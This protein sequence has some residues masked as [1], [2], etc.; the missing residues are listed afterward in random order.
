MLVGYLADTNIGPYDQPVPSVADS[1]RKID[2]LIE[3][4]IEAERAGFDSVLVPERHMRT[5]TYMP[6]ALTLLTILARETSKIRLG[7]YASVL[8]C[9]DPMQFAERAAQVDL[10]SHGRLFLTLARGYNSDYWRMMG[11]PEEKLTKRFIEGVEIVRRAFAGER[12]SFK[13][14]IFDLDDVFLTPLPYQRGEGPPIWGGGHFPAAIERAGTYSN[15]WSG[16]PFPYE[17]DFWKEVTTAYLEAAERSGRPAMI[18][19]MRDGFV[20]ETREK[21]Y[22]IFGDHVV[23]EN[24]F[25][26]RAGGHDP[27][28]RSEDEVTVENLRPHLVLGDPEDC[29]EALRH[30]ERDYG[31]EYVVLRMRMPEG[32]SLEQSIEAIRIFGDEVLPKVQTGRETFVHPALPPLPA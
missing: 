13:G 30:F 32:P 20:A 6:D 17:P 23:R 5:E 1:S 10:I 28:S 11:I 4:A 27:G 2:L 16:H 31:C 19:M 3:E 24:I 8:T 12:F 21:A 15:A 22:E 26:M 14:E 18:G 7:T 25:Y 9:H 29:V